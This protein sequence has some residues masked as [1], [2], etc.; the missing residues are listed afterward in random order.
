MRDSSARGP[1]PNRR[2]ALRCFANP[3]SLSQ[4]TKL[5]F[6]IAADAPRP[7]P[8]SNPCPTDSPHHAGPN[9]K[10]RGPTPRPARSQGGS[11][12][13]QATAWS[14]RRVRTMR[15][16]LTARRI[17]VVGCTALG[18]LTPAM[19]LPTAEG[20]AQILTPR[21]TRVGEKAY[22]AVPTAGQ[23][24]AQHRLGAQPR[25]HHRVMRE[26]QGGPRTASIP[27]G[28][29]PK[30]RRDLDCQKPRF[31]LWTPTT[32]KRPLSYG[33]SLRLLR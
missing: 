27:I 33:N 9:A 20:T 24:P 14:I 26:H 2:L 28:D 25:S 4:A 15:C 7:S 16:C 29:E 32:F 17:L 11:S 30:M 18:G 22:P 13:N 1:A 23:A 8:R 21:V 31:W 3:E 10:V 5:S 19:R 12:C 6:Q